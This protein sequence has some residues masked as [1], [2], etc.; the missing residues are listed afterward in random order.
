MIRDIPKVALLVET[1]LGYGRAFLRG[2]IRYA[3]LHGPW[4]FYLQPGD[5]RQLL[6]KMEEWGGTG[7][8]ARIETPEVAKAVLAARLPT[9]ALD[10]NRKQLA[11]NNPLS[12]LS[13]VRPDSHKAGGM[14]AEH[15]M[16]RGFRH[17]GFVGTWG[18]MLWSIR[19]SE[20][21]AKRLDESGRPGVRAHLVISDVAAAR[22][23]FGN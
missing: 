5:L 17:F 3:R 2:V 23:L 11:P 21:F 22:M 15:L 13:E 16:E 20:G 8:I 4:A 19:R 12:R 18:D 1:S 7:I 9:I 14:A 10:L 6:P